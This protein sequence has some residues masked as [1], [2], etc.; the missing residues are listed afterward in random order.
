M[1]RAAL[2]AGTWSIPLGDIDQ[3]NRKGCGMWMKDL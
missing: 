2:Y 3:P 1:N